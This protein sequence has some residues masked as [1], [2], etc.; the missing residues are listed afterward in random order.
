MRNLYEVD[1]IK[2]MY[3]PRYIYEIQYDLIKNLRDRLQINIYFQDS[4]FK[5]FIMWAQK[6]ALLFTRFVD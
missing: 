2:Q 3:L 4:I 5:E 6:S 1:K